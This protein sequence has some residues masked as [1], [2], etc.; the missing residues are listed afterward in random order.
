MSQSGRA[1]AE[2][3]VGRT[4][5]LLHVVG[6]RPN[7]MKVAPIM[8]AVDRWNAQ[9][10]TEGPANAQL[11]QVL[12]HTGQHYDEKMSKVFFEELGLPQP[13]HYL[14]VG[15]GSHAEQTA[16]VMMTIEPV[17]LAE[18]PDLMIVVG[19][20]N[21][22]LAAALVATK[23]GIAVAHVEAGLRSRDREMPEEINRILTDQIADL[24]FTTSRDA[25]EN[26]L[27][28]GIG[29]EK[30]HFAGNPMIDSLDTH[31]EKAAQSDIREKLGVE[32]GR[33]GVVTLHRPSNVDEPTGL[34]RLV[35][36]LTGVAAELPLVWPVHARTRVRLEDLG[37]LDNLST[38]SSLRMTEPLG[39][40]DFLALLSDARL[41]L[42]DSGGIQEETTVL[43]V[44]CLTLRKNTE[45]P[46][47]IW[48]GTNR[49]VDPE[50]E[51]R[52][53]KTAKKAL[54]D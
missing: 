16:K 13:D 38:N 26:L 37:L 34:E 7:F 50:D 39:Y 42:T 41:V 1:K 54:V 15:S 53:L 47:T 31:S 17:L 45:R 3:R 48:E 49:L 43:G 20:V 23:L 32:S 24:L 12:V 11:E 9:Q 27:A 22:T 52:I 18:R 10:P 36:V 46:V 44:P 28:E 29:P 19:D 4:F 2:R 5:K 6:T 35:R 51:D 21:S 25:G 33:Y 14:E 40:L 30:I 8:A